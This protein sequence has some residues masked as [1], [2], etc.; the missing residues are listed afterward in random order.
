M[1]NKNKRE[2]PGGGSRFLCDS[3]G[4]KRHAYSENISQ[5]AAR[6]VMRNAA[7]LFRQLRGAA[8]LAGMQQLCNTRKWGSTF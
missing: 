6:T 1:P 3:K 2:A 5:A 4:S 7:R 8:C